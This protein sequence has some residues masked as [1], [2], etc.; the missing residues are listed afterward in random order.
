MPAAESPLPSPPPAAQPAV[1]STAG[2][3]SDFE[4][5]PVDSAGEVLWWT[6]FAAGI[7]LATTA[8][9]GRDLAD[10]TRWI[11]GLAGLV[12]LALGLRA[13]AGR[14]REHSGRRRDE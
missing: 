11:T 14:V 12:A 3:R 6:T 10:A 9:A 1:D 2:P 13:L 4:P 8:A 5:P 7:A